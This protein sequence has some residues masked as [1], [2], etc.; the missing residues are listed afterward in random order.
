MTD[1][2]SP[3]RRCGHTPVMTGMKK[4]FHR[5]MV[6]KQPRNCKHDVE[7][8]TLEKP[9]QP[10]EAGESGPDRAGPSNHQA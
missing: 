10:R 9:G 4:R 2:K 5:E 6:S 8:L 3:F 1:K 7:A